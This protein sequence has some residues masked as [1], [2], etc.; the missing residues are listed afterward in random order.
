[1]NACIAQLAEET[2]E[3]RIGILETASIDKLNTLTDAVIEY[4]TVVETLAEASPL[5]RSVVV[6]NTAIDKA[7]T[8]AIGSKILI[9]QTNIIA[10]LTQSLHLIVYLL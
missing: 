8:M 2:D 4:A 7:A 1:M 6:D 3:P 9:A 10:I 5:T